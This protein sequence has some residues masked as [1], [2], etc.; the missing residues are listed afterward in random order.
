MNLKFPSLGK[1]GVKFFALMQL[2]QQDVVSLGELQSQLNINADQEHQLLKRLA[3]NGLIMRL[4]PGI[5]LVP[6]KL[7]TGGYWQ[8]NDYEVVAKYMEAIDAN[9]YINGMLAFN[10]YG[11][12]TQIPNEIMV[13]NDKISGVKNV[14]SLR[15]VM[16]KIP[17]QRI[18]ASENIDLGDDNRV[19]IASMPRA[20]FDAVYDWKRFGTLPEAYQWIKDRLSDKEFLQELVTLTV[21][22]GNMITTRRIGYFLDTNNVPESMTG[23]LLETL[24]SNT[25]WVVLDPNREPKGR[26]NQKWRVIDN[27]K[28]L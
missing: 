10:Y 6:E 15:L 3:R 18:N 1:L 22:Y 19:N 4:K 17:I 20:I 21:K 5:Y 26:T 11:L 12:T 24:K 28:D 27:A 13:Y 9:Y 23:P 8:P 7:P 16:A 25:G 2:K 14:G